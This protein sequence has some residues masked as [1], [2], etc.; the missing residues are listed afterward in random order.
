MAPVL[1]V[2]RDD[3]DRLAKHRSAEI[4]DCQFFAAGVDPG[5]LMSRKDPD[6][7]FRMLIVTT[8]SDI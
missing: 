2:G 6:W 4:L 1:M 7:S 8:L 3:L 5:P